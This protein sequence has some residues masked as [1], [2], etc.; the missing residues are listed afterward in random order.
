MKHQSINKAGKS[1]DSREI[2]YS[3]GSWER[4]GKERAVRSLGSVPY[5]L[6]PNYTALGKP[7]SPPRV[8]LIAWNVG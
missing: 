2:L 8:C 1:F 7:F 6:P 4:T 3:R 5:L